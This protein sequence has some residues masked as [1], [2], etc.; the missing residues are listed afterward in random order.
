MSA[1]AP[2]AYNVRDVTQRATL[3]DAFEAVEAAKKII[4]M[5]FQCRQYIF[6][7][8]PHSV[9]ATYSTAARELGFEIYELRGGRQYG[10][11]VA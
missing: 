8:P 1:V 3:L 10:L 11:R 2:V 9:Y 7:R 5:H 6:I 4:M